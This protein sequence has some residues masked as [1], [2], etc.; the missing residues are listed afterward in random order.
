MFVPS[1]YL[2]RVEDLHQA[3]AD[4]EE[5]GFTIVWGGDPQSAH[6]ALIYFESGGFLE[7]FNPGSSGVVD[8]IQRFVGRVGVAFGNQLMIRLMRWSNTRGLCDFAIETAQ[9]LLEGAEAAI[10]RGARLTKIRDFAR[11]QHD[12]VTTHWQIC[13]ADS[14]DLPFMMGP[15]DPPPQ[16]GPDEWSHA[17]GARHLKGMHIETED[18][19]Q[20]ARE[21][22]QLLGEVDVAQENGVHLVRSGDFTF[23]IKPGAA[24]RYAAIRI[25]QVPDPSAQLHGLELIFER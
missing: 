3:V 2:I 9:P 6:N 11:T 10:A 21:L 22:T 4:Y 14:A 16:V 19:A 1:H 24:H 18:P 12:G 13:R 23:T 25:D 17:N 7:L 5:A 20:Y 15:Y 8:A